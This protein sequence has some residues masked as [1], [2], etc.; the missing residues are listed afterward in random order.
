ML[1]IKLV[2]KF[3]NVWIYK[4]MKLLEGKN[5]LCFYPAQFSLSRLR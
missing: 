4:K 5:D 3:I 2:K 1:F